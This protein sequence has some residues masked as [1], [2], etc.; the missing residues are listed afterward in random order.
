[1]VTRALKIGCF[2]KEKKVSEAMFCISYGK[3]SKIEDN[4]PLDYLLKLPV[5]CLVLLTVY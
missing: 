5:V 3:K 2:E 4:V 1:M